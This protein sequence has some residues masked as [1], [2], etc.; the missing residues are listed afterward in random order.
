[1]LVR[2]MRELA[3]LRPGWR[4]AFSFWGKGGLEVNGADADVIAAVAGVPIGR[5]ETLVAVRSGYD[6]ID[7]TDDDVPFSDLARVA[8]FLLACDGRGCGIDGYLFRRHHVPGHPG[9]RRVDSK[10]EARLAG[11]IRGTSGVGCHGW[12]DD[13]VRLRRHA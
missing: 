13:G 4:E 8:W 5:A 12:D 7:G 6:G 1:M 9:S 2:G 3:S 11:S 10:F